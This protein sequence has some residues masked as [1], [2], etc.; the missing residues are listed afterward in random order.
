VFLEVDG[1]SSVFV[2]GRAVGGS[3]K[4]RL[5]FVVEPDASLLTARGNLAAVRVDHSSITDLYLGGILRPVL[6]V[7]AAA[8]EVR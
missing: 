3:D 1:T 6:L 4:R 5:P 2:N 7:S 8:G